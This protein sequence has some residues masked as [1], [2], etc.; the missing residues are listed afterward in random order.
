[1]DAIIFDGTMMKYRL[2]QKRSYGVYW[3]ESNPM[4]KRGSGQEKS[5]S[6]ALLH[7]WFSL[8]GNIYVSSLRVIVLVVLCFCCT[9]FGRRNGDKLFINLSYCSS[10]RRGGIFKFS[11]A[12]NCSSPRRGHSTECSASNSLCWINLGI[13]LHDAKRAR[14]ALPGI[15]FHEPNYNSSPHRK[16]D[17]EMP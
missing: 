11:F 14:S 5:G 16:E 12:H 17:T 10:P 4:N 6:Y 8:Y 15:W 3:K 7:S 2:K 13:P 1:V 9:D